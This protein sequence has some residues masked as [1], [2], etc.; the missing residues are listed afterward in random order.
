MKHCLQNMLSADST[1]RDPGRERQEKTKNSKYKVVNAERELKE[2]KLY[3]KKD[4]FM[5]KEMKRRK[6]TAVKEKGGWI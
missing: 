2:V 6:N 1:L 4:S 5:T 3:G